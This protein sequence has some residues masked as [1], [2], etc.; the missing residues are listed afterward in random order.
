MNPLINYRTLTG[1][2][3]ERPSGQ[4]QDILIA[5]N[6]LFLQ[7]QRTE[8]TVI[9]PRLWVPAPGLPGVRPLGEY[10]TLQL[11]VPKVP[12]ALVRQM[13]S[14]ARQPQP[15]METFFYLNWEDDHWQL[16]QPEQQQTAGWVQPLGV[17]QGRSA[18]QRAAIEVHTHPDG[19]DQFS[20]LDTQ[21]ATGFRIFALITNLSTIPKWVVRVGNEGF[22][23]ALPAHTIFEGVD[24]CN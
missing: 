12:A 4:I 7:R 23:M 17:E 3:I 14:V 24:S 22:F 8:F 21:S 13:V 2:I 19:Y 16:Y 18:Y 15:F 5:Q 10:E 6:G 11:H 1:P 9:L 20:E